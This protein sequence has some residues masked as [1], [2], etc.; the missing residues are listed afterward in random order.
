MMSRLFNAD[1]L[2]I[3]FFIWF[4]N[5]ATMGYRMFY[6]VLQS[7]VISPYSETI[8]ELLSKVSSEV[9]KYVQLISDR[10]QRKQVEKKE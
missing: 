7:K 4:S 5:P 10:V 3:P 9:N 8:E 1:L 2:K 6:D